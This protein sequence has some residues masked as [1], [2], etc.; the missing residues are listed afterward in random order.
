MN[1]S[2][3]VPDLLDTTKPMPHG[4]TTWQQPLVI[5]IT[6]HWLVETVDELVTECK[7]HIAKE[8]QSG[9]LLHRSFWQNAKIHWLLVQIL[10][11]IQWIITGSHASMGRMRPRV[12]LLK[13]GLHLLETAEFDLLLL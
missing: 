2:M 4:R 12:N 8:A 7:V 11:V 5:D 6:R 9:G 13:I 10:V 3:T 1:K